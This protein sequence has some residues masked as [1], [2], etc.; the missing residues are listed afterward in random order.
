MG[1]AKFGSAEGEERQKS[2]QSINVTVAM[3]FDGTDNNKS[4]TDARY[5]TDINIH[6]KYTNNTDH[7]NSSYENDHSNVAKLW[8]NYTED[9]ANYKFKKY[10]GG[11]G[12]TDGKKDS[13]LGSTFGSGSTGILQKVEEGC[14]LISDELKSVFS[15]QMNKKIVSTLTVDV[16]G[17]SRGSAAARN[18][19][20][21]ITKP[22]SIYKEEKKSAN[23][24]NLILVDDIAPVNNLKEVPKYGHLGRFCRPNGIEIEFINIRFVGL[25]DCV[26][27]YNKNKIGGIFIPPRSSYTSKG[28]QDDTP[29]VFKNDTTQLHLDV[30]GEK[31]KRVVHFTAADEHR[32][33]FPLTNIESAKSN[34]ATFSFP[35][36]HSDV[37]GGYPDNMHEN[38]HSDNTPQIIL[39]GEYDDMIKEKERLKL[40]GWFYEKE[41][42]IK[43]QYLNEDAGLYRLYAERKNLRNTYSFIP[44]HLM[45]QSALDFTTKYSSKN[46]ILFN[47][48]KIENDKTTSVKNDKLLEKIK[49]KLVDYLFNN[50]QPLKLSSPKLMEVDVPSEKQY[51]TDATYVKMQSPLQDVYDFSQDDQDLIALRHSYLHWNSNYN[52][53]MVAEVFEIHPM[54]PRMVDSV[55]ERLPLKG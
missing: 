44:L 10:I 7:N 31:A 38:N 21:E 1:I 33:N 49:V 43:E 51:D 4:N 32:G 37:G 13:A 6:E 22:G 17:F 48:G 25:F 2:T 11:I 42:L 47:V 9:K 20:Y 27:S 24:N 53:V 5:S 50:G 40:E 23:Q 18:F 8:S 54:Y 30:I 29:E 34:G 15:S 26:A 12:T 16:F 19:V 3:F 45:C 14:K 36:V 46:P 28:F 55:R 39:C 35:G 41:L 52:N